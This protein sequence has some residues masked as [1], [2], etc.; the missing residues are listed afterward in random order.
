VD[1]PIYLFPVYWLIFITPV[2]EELFIRSFLWRFLI[3]P[4]VEDVA[5]GEYSA[6]AFWGTASL[7]ALSHNEWI[8]AFLYALIMNLFL[9][10]KKDIK[11][12]MIAHGFSNT[13]LTTY[14]LISGKWSL[15]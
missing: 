11:L 12:C 15:W 14:V 3:N 7:F 4:R 10:I 9:G 6:L 1:F 5:V 13:I 8:V 2:F